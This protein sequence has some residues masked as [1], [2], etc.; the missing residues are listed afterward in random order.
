MATDATTGQPIFRGAPTVGLKNVGSYQISGHPYM[1]G[2]ILQAGLEH[3]VSFP[4]VTK[5][6]TVTISGSITAP[7]QVRVSF[8]PTGSDGDVVGAFHYAFFDSSEDSQEFDVKCK[9]IYVTSV[10]SA[11]FEVFAELTTIPTASMWD[12]AISGSG[13][14]GS[15]HDFSHRNNSGGD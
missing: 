9:E 10:G 7:T 14:L 4:Y 12:L 13:L 3:K 15:R 1:T 5:K 11:G 8:V 6:V 2:A